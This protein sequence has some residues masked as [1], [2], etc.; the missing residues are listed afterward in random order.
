M[1][2]DVGE[3]EFDLKFRCFGIPVRVTPW[4][5]LGGVISGRG[6]ME[7]GAFELLVIWI[8]CL[9]LSILVHE[10]GHAFAA[11]WF[12]WPPE[13]ILYQFGG[14]A[15]FQ[16]YHGYTT[17]RSI[18][19]SFAGPFAGFVLGGFFLA[20]AIFVGIIDYELTQ[21]MDFALYQLIWINFAWGLVNLLPVLPLD[22][23]RIAQALIQHF[24]PRD[25]YDWTLKLSMVTAVLATAFFLATREFW[26]LF[27]ALLFGILF[28]ANLQSYQQERGSW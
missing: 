11:R 25:G 23:G 19:V 2:G 17:L 12:G 20:I 24:R 27:P 7:S 18:V 5:W 22:G 16:P 14:L 13:V 21:G 1:F 4:F 15:V 28:I 6:L 9:F 3:S 8:A 26:G 10:M